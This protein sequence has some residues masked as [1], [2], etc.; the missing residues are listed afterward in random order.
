MVISARRRGDNAPLRRAFGTL[1]QEKNQRY[2]NAIGIKTRYRD[3]AV[4]ATF[5][6]ALLI[7]LYLRP[8]IIKESR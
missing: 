7:A 4:L 2:P 3:K 6:V 1:A 8:H 5:T